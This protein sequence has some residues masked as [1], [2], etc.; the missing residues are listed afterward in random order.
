MRTL[1]TQFGALALAVVGAAGA[2]AQT[3]PTIDGRANAADGY[4]LGLSTQ[5]TNTQ[6]GNAMSG[7]P[8]NGG[9]GSEI[10]QIFA[11]VANGRLYVV[12][13]GNLETNFNKLEVFID[14]EAGGVNSI[15]GTALPG[16]VDGFCCGGFPPP[17]GTNDTNAGALQ[18]M[19][20]LTFDPDFAADHYL[21]FTHGFENALDPQLRFYAASAHYAD[22]TDGTGG[23]KGALGIQLAQRGLPQ[24]LRG[25]TSDV[26]VDGDVDGNDLLIIQ[27]NMGSTGLNQGTSRLMGDATGDGN[28]DAADQSQWAA[29]F[30]FT[31]ATATF[32]A[33][34]FAPQNSNVDDSNVLLGPTLPGLSQGD[35]IDKTYAFGPGGA[36]DNAGTGAITRELEFVLPPV[37]GTT[38]AASHRNMDNIVDLQMAIDNSNVGGVSGAGPYT[39][40]TTEDVAQVVSGIEFSIPLSEI[41]S[42]SGAIKLFFFVNGGGHDY[43][44]NQ[45][46]GTGI[47]DGNLGGNGFGGFTGDL[48]GVNMNDFPG[49]QYVTV[50]Q[51]GA[52][53]A[54]PE[55]AVASL[56]FAAVA[57]LAVR[58][59]R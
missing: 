43:A 13:A 54:V 21:T 34:Y 23:R 46:S 35:L 4:G 1:V 47:L 5:N 2:L 39:E 50:T 18:R 15:T 26:D 31:N 22:L 9:G 16:G 52:L 45:F 19:Q 14:S 40:P 37:A 6:F 36:T 29:S 20:G 55:P 56:V 58:R 7:D 10:D 12:M 57:A 32:G 8:I 3:A 49:N 28:V 53:A 24:V 42:P 11:K 27:R 51:G 38:N 44:S 25:T 59:R 33:N 17:D 41:G 48:S 30:G